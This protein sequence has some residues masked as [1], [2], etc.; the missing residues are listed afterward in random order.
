MLLPG[1]CAPSTVVVC[2]G[3]AVSQDT[4]PG[5]VDL[6]N[7]APQQDRERDMG[8]RKR[9]VVCAHASAGFFRSIGRVYRRR[10]LL[11]VAGTPALKLEA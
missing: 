10:N 7:S 11:D 4:P 1:L 5:C 8:R 9:Y 3:H 2:I 6:P